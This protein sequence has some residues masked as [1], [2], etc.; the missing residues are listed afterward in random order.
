M[1]LLSLLL[2]IVLVSFA[3]TSTVIETVECQDLQNCEKCPS[4]SIGIGFGIVMVNTEQSG[5]RPQLRILL[6]RP[7]GPSTVAAP[8]ILDLDQGYPGWQHILP[9]PPT[10]ITKTEEKKTR[11]NHVHYLSILRRNTFTQ[12]SPRRCSDTPLQQH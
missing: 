7:T 9:L 3:L 5:D 12:I 6:T 2:L 4:R 10:T 8:P 11:N 1:L